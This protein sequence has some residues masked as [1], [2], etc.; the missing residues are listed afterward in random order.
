MKK[1]V[2]SFVLVALLCASLCLF[3]ACGGSD[4]DVEFVETPYAG[5]SLLVYNWGENISDGTEGSLD[6]I[7][8]FEE[9]YDIDVSYTNYST[10]EEL[11]S[12]L[13]NGAR[14]DVVIPS[15][16]MIQRLV[17]EN[18][19]QK[20]DMNNVTNYSLIDDKYKGLYFDPDNAYSVPYTVGRVGIIYNTE[21]VDAEDLESK[22][23][24]L[25]WKTDKYRVINFKNP[26]DA[27]G[28]AMFYLQLDVNETDPAVWD[29]AYTKL[30]AQR[31]GGAMY[32][33]DEIYGK[34]EGGNADVAAYY[35]GD[36]L[37]MM[38][39]NESLGFYYPKEGTNTFVDSMC[40]PTN[41]ENKGAAEL[42]INF[43][44]DPEIATA[45][46]NY[47]CYAS[48]NTAVLT[49]ED[50]DYPVGTPEHEIL[51]GEPESYIANPEILQYYHRL[52]TATQTYMDDLWRQLFLD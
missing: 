9:K 31:K 21:T 28:T 8:Y 43:M 22:S 13:K 12:E 52:D 17:A 11:Y 34:M 23:W 15:D 1:I 18:L 50:Y 35:A 45:N 20:I 36:C 16:Y 29:T 26:R 49:H 41:A 25:L 44:L 27:F 39:E 48:P 47:I 5:T 4:M 37:C 33:M 2:A 30:V 40:I 46:A 7:R 14:Y 3:S 10:N 51:Y 6:V 42:F 38:Q 32:L 19:I 24:D